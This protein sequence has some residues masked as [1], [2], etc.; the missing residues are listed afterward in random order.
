MQHGM[1][2]RLAQQ[3]DNFGFEQCNLAFEIRPAGSHFGSF[4]RPVTRWPAFHGIGNVN[5]VATRD[6]ERSQHVVEQLPGLPHEWFPLNILVGTRPFADKKPIRVQISDA[7][8]GLLALLVITGR[9]VGTGA[10]QVLGVT[11]KL[12]RDETNEA[13]SADLFV[14]GEWTLSPALVASAGVRSG[15]LRQVVCAL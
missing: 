4:R 9:F 8:H 1:N 10:A 6:V 5:P 2:R 13:R 12:R 15:K 14:Q 7:E 11:G 3:H